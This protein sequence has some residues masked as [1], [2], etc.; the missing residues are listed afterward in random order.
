M[1]VI[2]RTENKGVNGRIIESAAKVLDAFWTLA[3]GLAEAV[4][5][6]GQNAIIDIAYV[7]HVDVRQRCKRTQQAT[8]STPHARDRHCDA[9]VR[10]F[11]SICLRYLN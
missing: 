8:A 2:R 3:I 9:A 10:K 6:A 1:P 4:E 11:F 7:F 5:T